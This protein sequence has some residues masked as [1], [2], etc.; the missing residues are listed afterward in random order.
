MYRRLKGANSWGPPLAAVSNSATS[1][2]DLTAEAGIEYEYWLQ[3]MYVGLNPSTAMG[4]ISAGVKVPQ[5]D[6][7]G[8]LLLLVDDTMVAPLAPEIAQLRDDLTADG[9]AVQ[10][11]TALRSGT[12]ASTKALIAAA[13]NDS[14]S[15]VADPVARKAVKMVYILGHVPVPYSGFAL[16]PDGH[17][18]RAL[19]A[20]GY[21]GDMDG[22]WTDAATY[23]HAITSKR[24]ENVANDGSVE[25]AEGTVQRSF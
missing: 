22:T 6:S 14:P 24:G 18:N 23:G 25:S 1:S 12:A 20:D 8:T 7:R 13:Y 5:T 11:I 15:D 3:R 9:W 19:P 16:D 4:Y 17:G 21:Y 10:Q 2:W